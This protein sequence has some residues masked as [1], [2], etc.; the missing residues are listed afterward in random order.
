MPS[1]AFLC[2][3][4]H[5]GKR[6]VQLSILGHHLFIEF[7]QPFHQ[8]IGRMAPLSWIPIRQVSSKLP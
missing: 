4:N 5:L 3:C 6:Y 8:K 2:A 7:F 1:M